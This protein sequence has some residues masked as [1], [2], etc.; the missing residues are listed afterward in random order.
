MLQQ[1]DNELLP[2]Y[3]YIFR[4]AGSAGIS[5]ET[6]NAMLNSHR[7]FYQIIHIFVSRRNQKNH[8]NQIEER[9][10]KSSESSKYQNEVLQTHCSGS[11]DGKHRIG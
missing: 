6:D 11:A 3:I 10:K 2:P 8:Q 1:R 4:A 7:H 9:K 5:D